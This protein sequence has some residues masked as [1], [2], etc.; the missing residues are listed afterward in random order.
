MVAPP[1]TERDASA[2]EIRSSDCSSPTSPVFSMKA[3]RG[4]F[5]P[6]TSSENRRVRAEAISVVCIV[7]YCKSEG[8]SKIHGAHQDFSALV[9]GI[10]GQGIQGRRPCQD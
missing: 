4:W 5:A 8:F 10:C 1:S 2:A 7:Q 6:S 9:G 3:P